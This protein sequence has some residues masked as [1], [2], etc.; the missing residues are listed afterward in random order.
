M[1]FVSRASRIADFLMFRFRFVVFL[2]RM[3]LWNAFFRFTF[4]VPVREKR[5]DAPLCVF[6]FG[7]DYSL[8]RYFFGDTNITMLRPSIRGCCST[9]ATLSNSSRMDSMIFRP[10]DV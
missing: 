3:W 2:V 6:C 10:I 5:F 8:T 1:P 7:I 4:P 9:V